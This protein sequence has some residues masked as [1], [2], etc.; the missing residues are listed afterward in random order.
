MVC[1]DY[2]ST[3]TLLRTRNRAQLQKL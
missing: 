2:K 3:N 1:S